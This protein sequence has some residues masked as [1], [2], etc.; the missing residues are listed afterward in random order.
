MRPKQFY[1]KS[2]WDLFVY[3]VLFVLLT[4]YA[5]FIKGTCEELGCLAI[6]IPILAIMGMSVI[7]FFANIWVYSKKYHFSTERK[8]VFVI[9]GIIAVFSLILILFSL[10]N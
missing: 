2:N 4:S 10:V 1:T 9:S 5:F 3:V 6:I 8:I 7:E